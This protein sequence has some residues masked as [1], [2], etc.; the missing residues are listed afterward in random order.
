MRIR[1]PRLFRREWCLA[2]ALL[3][4]RPLG[5]AAPVDDGDRWFPRHLGDRWDYE[6]DRLATWRVAGKPPEE[7]RI[8]G[9]TTVTVSSLVPEHGATEATLESTL[10]TQIS[11]APP[12]P[13]L[14]LTRTSFTSRSARGLFLHASGRRTGDTPAQAS[15]FDDGLVEYDPP[16]QLVALPL[17]AGQTWVTGPTHDGGLEVTL[18]ARVIGF[19]AVTTPAGLFRHCVKIARRGTISGRGNAGST[20]GRPLES[21]SLDRIEWIAEGVG[22][23]KQWQKRYEVSTDAAARRLVTLDETTIKTLIKYRVA[24]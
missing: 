20:M 2:L 24:K 1:A 3:A 9:A 21:G 14:R 6:V 15:R 12:P 16:L 4:A 19:E 22:T 18:T 7:V 17:T 13:P 5:A 23:V 8:R 11:P 10:Y